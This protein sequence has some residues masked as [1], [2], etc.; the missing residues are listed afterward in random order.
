MNNLLTVFFLEFEV[1]S[2]CMLPRWNPKKQEE[3]ADYIG[4]VTFDNLESQITRVS[5]SG[6]S[7]IK[8][9]Y[10][11]KYKAMSV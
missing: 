11:L 5:D 2:G 4:D 10:S 7:P 6:S 9:I 1:L 8:F 3:D